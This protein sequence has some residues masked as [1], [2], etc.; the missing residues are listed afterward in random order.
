MPARRPN[1]GWHYDRFAQRR[2]ASTARRMELIM[3]LR[4]IVGVVLCAVGTLWILQG[5]KVITG[6]SMS[7]EGK[8]GVIGAVVLLVGLACLALAVR[9]WRRGPTPSS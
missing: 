9:R 6:S 7:G 1:G 5:T 2:S 3:W 4:G 8:W